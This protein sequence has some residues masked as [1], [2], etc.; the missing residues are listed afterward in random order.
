MILQCLLGVM[1]STYKLLL[2]VERY[3]DAWYFTCTIEWIYRYKGNSKG[4]WV[5]TYMS[6]E[7]IITYA[8]VWY[9]RWEKPYL[10]STDWSVENN[11]LFNRDFECCM[12]IW[13]AYYLKL[14]LGRNRWS[15]VY[16]IRTLINI[17]IQKY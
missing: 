1:L 7:K 10:S 11:C 13:M 12:E 5:L 15:L 17:T 4:I 9:W 6:H 2:R 8:C 3:C 14:K 16:V